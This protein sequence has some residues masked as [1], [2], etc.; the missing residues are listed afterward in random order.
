MRGGLGKGL[1]R[2]LLARPFSLDSYC[3][4]LVGLEVVV[5]VVDAGF[6]EAKRSSGA[7]FDDTNIQGRVT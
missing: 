7:V 4:C 2:V 3:A 6:G 1:E 5:V